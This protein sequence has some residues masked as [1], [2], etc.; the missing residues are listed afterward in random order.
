MNKSAFFGKISYVT[1]KQYIT[2][3]KFP[4]KLPKNHPFPQPNASSQN[5]TSNLLLAP[6]LSISFPSH[7]QL[8]SYLSP[9]QKILSG[10]LHPSP[11]Y[12]IRCIRGVNITEQMY[13]NLPSVYRMRQRNWQFGKKQLL[14]Q[15]PAKKEFLN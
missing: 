10:D 6:I 12:S 8:K 1:K 7:K 11:A 5:L 15:G 13:S 4:I 2:C 14:G 9:K 3:L